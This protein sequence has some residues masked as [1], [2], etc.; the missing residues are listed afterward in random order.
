MKIEVTGETKVFKKMFDDRASYSTSI[1]KK[2]QDDT[3]DNA[4]I[5]LQFKKGVDIADGT[6]IDIQKGWLTFYINKDK[7]PVW[8]IFVSEFE[9]EKGSLPNGFEDV[10]SID[11]DDEEIPF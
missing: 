6:K 1:G 7:K 3:W 5:N 11:E 8:Q 2:K 9:S 10:T 4:Y